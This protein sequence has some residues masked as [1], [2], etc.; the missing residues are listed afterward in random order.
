[1][2]VT[3]GIRMSFLF[4]FQCLVIIGMRNEKK[5][6][7]NNTLTHRESKYKIPIENQLKSHL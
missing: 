1:M 6:V 3:M 5:Q 2:F 7:N 4:A